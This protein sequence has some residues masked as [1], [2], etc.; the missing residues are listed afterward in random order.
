MK[1]GWQT[2][3]FWLT[4]TAN[5]LAFA[6]AFGIVPL[7]DQSTV[8][9]AVTQIVTGVF[10]LL[11]GG[12]ALW[13]YID[14]RRALKWGMLENEYDRWHTLAFATSEKREEVIAGAV[15]ADARQEAEKVGMPW[16]TLI[17]LAIQYRGELA[18]LIEAIR[19][20]RKPS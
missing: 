16:L 9:G 7:A 6:V 19:N 14:S 10:A 8:S 3:E 12:A 2:S 13:K 18:K 1:S 11:A 4:L 17:L 5:V 20:W 15:P